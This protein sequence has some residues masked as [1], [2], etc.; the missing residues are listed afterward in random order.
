M[1]NHHWQWRFWQI[2]MQHQWERLQPLPVILLATLQRRNCCLDSFNEYSS[3]TCRCTRSPLKSVP[4]YVSY[5]IHHLVWSP[6]HFAI[7]IHLVLEVF[8]GCSIALFDFLLWVWKRC[9][10]PSPTQEI[11]FMISLDLGYKKSTVECPKIGMGQENQWCVLCLRDH[12]SG[13]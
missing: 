11:V 6:L 2:Q 3:A 7:Q 12:W 4:L 5:L 10:T 1:H 13:L 9:T 8:H